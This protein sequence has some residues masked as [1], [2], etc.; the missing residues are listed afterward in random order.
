MAGRVVDVERR[1]Q[2]VD[3]QDPPGRHVQRRLADDGRRRRGVDQPP[4]RSGQ[5]VERAVGVHR[6]ALEGRGHGARTTRRV[7]FKLDAPN[8]SFPYYLSSD[9]YNA[10]I[11]PAAY[12]GDFAKTFPG[13]GPWKL[14]T[15]QE[16][17]GASFVRNDG[18]WGK[19]AIPDKLEVTFAADEAAQI[20]ALQGNQL[21]VVQQV[22]VSGAQAILD[23]PAY[24]IIALQS[25][26]HRQLSMRTD[27]KPFDDAKRA[28]GASPW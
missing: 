4:G 15:Y 25:A 17:V 1:R 5:Q 6:R 11:L 10:I 9:N 19:K 22:S 21:D 28:A 8:G 14:D 7:V 24:A 26:A 18:Y 27:K 3:L 23:D 2:R 20:L 13:T 12:A 16:G